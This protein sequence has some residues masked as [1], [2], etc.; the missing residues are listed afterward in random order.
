MATAL[1]H[2]GDIVGLSASQEMRRVHACWRV[3]PMPDNQAWGGHFS[4]M[5][6]PGEA[7]S[8]VRALSDTDAAITGAHQRCARPQPASRICL[9]LDAAH[10]GIKVDGQ[11][12]QVSLD[13]LK[14]EGF[15]GFGVVVEAQH[16][17][18]PIAHSPPSRAATV[19]REPIIGAQ[20]QPSRSGPALAT[21]ERL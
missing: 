6:G 20:L 17:N 16:E 15:G 18:A 10:E 1:K 7:V 5:N 13:V 11:Y 19:R 14:A 3:A 21:A 4:V 2:V 8:P 12:R 9:K